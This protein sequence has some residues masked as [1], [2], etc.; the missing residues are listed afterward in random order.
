VSAIKRRKRYADAHCAGFTRFSRFRTSK[1]IEFFRSGASF[2]ARG[3]TASRKGLR[4][5]ISSQP[6]VVDRRLLIFLIVKHPFRRK[7]PTGIKIISKLS[8]QLKVM[9]Q[10]VSPKNSLPK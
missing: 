9:L 3:K 4:R 8:S 5:T 6:C 2:S 10:I 7:F 1:K